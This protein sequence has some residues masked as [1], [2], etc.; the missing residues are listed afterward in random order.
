[1]NVKQRG[2]AQGWLLLIMLIVLAAAVAGAIG[3]WNHYI[4]GVETRAHDAGVA[5]TKAAYEA[6]DNK[7]LA[8]A[9]AER[10]AAQARL[11]KALA[12]NQ[13]LTD[14]AGADY[15]KGVKDGKDQ[16]ARDVAAVRAGTL[17]LHDPGATACVAG[18][19][20]ASAGDGKVAGGE[21]GVAGTGNPG[22]SAGASEFL[23]G[24]AAEAN[25]LRDKVKALQAV[26][27]ADHAQINGQ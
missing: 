7:A 26:V 15:A 3:A 27:V 13:K 21:A 20:Q 23:L 11:D 9:I 1:M 6:R 4:S 8:D 18:S 25:R 2:I 14:A 17:V 5:E 22:L 12:D 10:N 19:G 16:A 24:L